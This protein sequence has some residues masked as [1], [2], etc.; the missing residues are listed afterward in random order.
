MDACKEVPSVPCVLRILCIL[1]SQPILQHSDAMAPTVGGRIQHKVESHERG[2]PAARPNASHSTASASFVV[3]KVS[4]I[5][6]L[7]W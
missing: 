7:I 1:C 3:G 6:S 4:E 5:T 2:T